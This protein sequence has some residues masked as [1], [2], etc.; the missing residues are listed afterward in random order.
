[1]DNQWISSAVLDVFPIEPLPKDSPLWDHPRV[2]STFEFTFPQTTTA[3][4]LIVVT[5][6]VSAVSL[7]PDVV[8]VFLSNLA[9]FAA[10]KPLQFVVDPTRGY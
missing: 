5:P 3:N 7:A 8:N 2:I 6:H 4:Q 1:L 9:L 10:N